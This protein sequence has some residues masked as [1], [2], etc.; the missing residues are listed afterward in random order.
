MRKYS[1]F[2]DNDFERSRGSKAT[3]RLILLMIVLLISTLRYEC[4]NLSYSRWQGVL[5][6]SQRVDTPILD[7]IAHQASELRQQF[8]G[9][10]TSAFRK[11]EWKPMTIVP[12]A[13][14]FAAV[15][16]WFLRRGI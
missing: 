3:Q 5:G 6:R 4:G 14:G 12:M 10:G 7:M 8:G 1:T 13:F 11:I 15:G 2:D 9:A 16:A